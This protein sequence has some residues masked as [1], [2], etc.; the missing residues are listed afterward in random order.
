MT[1]IYEKGQTL[2][3]ESEKG[4]IVRNLRNMRQFY[5]A[6][7]KR[8][9]VCTE[10]SWSHYRLLMRVEDEEIKKMNKQKKQSIILI[11][12]SWSGLVSD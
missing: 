4:Y 6:F 3:T 8:N 2:M 10:L 7:P 11:R 12:L 9:T 5:M 1:A